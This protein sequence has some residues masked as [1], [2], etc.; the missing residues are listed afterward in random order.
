[1][2]STSF[3][4]ARLRHGSAT[5]FV[6]LKDEE[7]NRVRSD[8]NVLLAGNPMRMKLN[9]NGST[10]VAELWFEVREPEDLFAPL[11]HGATALFTT[12]DRKRFRKCAF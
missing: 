12:A 7:V 2:A 9:A 4:N 10:P 5:A 3:I 11:A 6:K 1:M 8:L